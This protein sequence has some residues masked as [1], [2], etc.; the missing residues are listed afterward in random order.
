MRGFQ[1]SVEKWSDTPLYE[2]NA[3]KV[4]DTIKVEYK[5]STYATYIP[6]SFN[7]S[8]LVLWF[9]EEDRKRK[10]NEPNEIDYNE[11]QAALKG[12]KNRWYKIV[13]EDKSR[14]QKKFKQ[15]DW[16]FIFDNRP[17]GDYLVS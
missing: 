11:I 7:A 15:L 13:Q 1:M 9:E 14:F 6:K 12:V 4:I 2:R 5:P 8:P 10:R 16:K 17:K 3:K